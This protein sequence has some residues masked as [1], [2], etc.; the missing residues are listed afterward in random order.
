MGLQI[1]DELIFETSEIHLNDV[2]N[3]ASDIME[4]ANLPYLNLD[5][6]LKVEGDYGLNWS[7]AH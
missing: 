4:K 6:P 2:L 1:H 7:K 5:V 3:S